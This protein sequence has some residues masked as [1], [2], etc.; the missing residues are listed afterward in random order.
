[1]KETVF[2]I[3]LFQ[4]INGITC[5]LPA[6]DSDHTKKKPEPSF[7]DSGYKLGNDLLS[8]DLTSNYHWRL[9]A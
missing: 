4:D 1:M 6:D 7:E 5:H 8:R 2:S 3:V 9:R